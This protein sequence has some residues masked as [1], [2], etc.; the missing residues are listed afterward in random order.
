MKL[1]T[2]FL[3]T[4]N[5]VLILFVQEEIISNAEVTSILQTAAVSV[6]QQQEY[7]EETSIQ[8]V[9]AIDSTRTGFIEVEITIKD[10][11]DVYAT[12]EES[13]SSSAQ[14]L[15]AVN[16]AEITEVCEASAEREVTAEI[17][18]TTQERKWS[19]FLQKPKTPKPKPKMKE[20]ERPKVIFVYWEVTK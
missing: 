6:E 1:R 2:P 9:N 13:A 18:S 14:A 16:I 8:A 10:Q 17:Q 15:Q 4:K 7:S 11:Q 12:E 19:T 20:P 5:L 3:S